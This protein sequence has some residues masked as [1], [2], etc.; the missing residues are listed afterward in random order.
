MY[1]LPVFVC[2]CICE[3][4]CAT[5]GE[6]ELGSIIDQRGT[7][8]P[9]E[10]SQAETTSFM[11]EV[12]RTKYF[13]AVLVQQ[14]KYSYISEIELHLLLRNVANVNV[15]HPTFRHKGIDVSL[16]AL[17]RD[18]GQDIGRSNAWPF[19]PAVRVPHPAMFFSCPLSSPSQLLLL[20]ASRCAKLRW[21]LMP[22]SF[23]QTL[24]QGCIALL[25]TAHARSTPMPPARPA[26]AKYTRPPSAATPLVAH[27]ARVLGLCC[28]NSGTRQKNPTNA[29]S[30][31]FQNG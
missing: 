11:Y 25:H 18:L 4:V 24:P 5:R 3:V 12:L 2:V 19:L 26:S 22:W 23:Q 20:C 9:D 27:Q 15:V 17:Q 7:T 21:M 14:Y 28:H 16:L 1:T 13:S 8:H 6:W 30:S 10:N 29:S 31:L